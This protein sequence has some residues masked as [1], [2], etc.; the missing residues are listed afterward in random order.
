MRYEVYALIAAF[1]FGLNA[2]LMCKAMRDSS[3]FTATLSVAAVQVIFLS[4]ILVFNRPP[5]NWIA[6]F[7]FIFAGFWQQ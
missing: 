6:I 7:Y 4:S 1:S 3:P 2:V 5:L